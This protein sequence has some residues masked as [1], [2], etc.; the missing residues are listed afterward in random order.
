M[1]E[2]SAV[3]LEQE[4][5]SFRSGNATIISGNAQEAL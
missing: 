1:P 2:F 4:L 3:L 5:K